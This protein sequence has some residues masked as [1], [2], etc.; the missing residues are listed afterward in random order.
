MKEELFKKGLDYVLLELDIL[1]IQYMYSAV[2]VL[3][4]F[5]FAKKHFLAQPGLRVIKVN[6]EPGGDS[7]SRFGDPGHNSQHLPPGSWVVIY[8]WF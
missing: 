6:S 1:Y 4:Y 5:H 8:F 2:V 3:I 7:Q